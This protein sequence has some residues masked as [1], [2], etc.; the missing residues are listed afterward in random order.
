MR[1][2]DV[3]LSSILTKIGNGGMLTLDEMALLESQFK[4]REQ[5]MTDAPTPY[6]YFRETMAL[7]N[8]IT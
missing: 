1:R 2:G 3:V 6:V 8:K 4:S 7:K 5:S